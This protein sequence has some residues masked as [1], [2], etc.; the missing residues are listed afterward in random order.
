MAA[1]VTQPPQ[2]GDAVEVAG[3]RVGEGVRRGTILEVLGEES[4]PHYRVAWEDG[5]E[6]MLYPSADVRVTRKRSRK[7]ATR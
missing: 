6:T 2:A 3:H 5:H 4:R 1:T 7:R